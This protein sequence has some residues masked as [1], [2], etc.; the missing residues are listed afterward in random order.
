MSNKAASQGHGSS[1]AASSLEE[2]EDWMDWDRTTGPDPSGGTKDPKEASSETLSQLSSPQ[3]S[4]TSEMRLVTSKKRK[5]SRENDQAAMIVQTPSQDTTSAYNRSHSIIEKRYRTNLNRKIAD[6]GECIPNLR[7]DAKKSLNGTPVTSAQKHNK[8][9]V[10]ME[11]IEYIHHLERRNA[12]LQQSNAALQ[13]QANKALSE[14]AS[15]EEPKVEEASPKTGGPVFPLAENSNPPEMSEPVQGMIRVPEDF[16]RLWNNELQPYAPGR[17]SRPTSSEGSAEGNVSVKGKRYIGRVMLGSLAGLMVM[18]GLASTHKGKREDRGLSSLPLFRS[19]PF[20]PRFFVIR[21]SVMFLPYSTLHSPFTSAFLVFGLLGLMLFIYLF[22]SRPPARKTGLSLR[23]QLQQTSRLQAAPSLASPLEVR[24]RAW[25]TSIQTVWVPRHHVF[26]E[27]LALIL[28]TATYLTRLLLGW[29]SYSWLTG[30]SEEEEVA[31]V[32]AW[33]IAI[34]AQLSGGDPEISR[35]RLVLTLWA[36]GTLPNTPYRLMLKALHLRV[37]FWQ[38]SRFQWLSE[39]L[40]RVAGRLARYQW[41]KA[42]RMQISLEATAS[43][44]NIEP[45]SEHLNALL[46]RSSHEAMTDSTVQRAH[47]LVWNRPINEESHNNGGDVDKVVEDSAMRGPL[48]ALASWYSSVVLEDALRASLDCDGIIQDTVVLCNLDL[49]LQTAASGSFGKTRALAASAALHAGKRAEFTLDLIQNL[50]SS[51]PTE[52]LSQSSVTSA[53]ASAVASFC[54]AD[55]LD[56]LAVCL[57]CLVVLNTLI[58]P[59]NKAEN[60]VKAMDLLQT[61]VSE[62]EEISL[63]GFAT[64]HALLMLTSTSDIPEIQQVVGVDYIARRL[65]DVLDSLSA[66]RTH[67]TPFPQ[68]LFVSSLKR[69][70]ARGKAPLGERRA[71]GIS[72]DTGYESMD[73][74]NDL[75]KTVYLDGQDDASA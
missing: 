60:T 15:D 51:T 66:Q 39:L 74:E 31:R 53:L 27:L 52:K 32:R 19:L 59:A 23:S 25:L 11:A 58:D 9:T 54:G 49:A 13:D 26:P 68:C 43:E 35:S 73:D 24:Q 16:R 45:L 48:D 28:E 36:A 70:L 50:S 33:D 6:L 2:W 17:S 41:T 4:T 42:H 57:K 44:S 1:S 47:N 69:I 38:P 61:I 46:Q 3:T 12:Y 71:S 8:A 40:H 18:D 10:L 72:H 75:M 67:L 5:V 56:D 37:L 20:S 64:F 30:R 14:S 7:A 21:S 65:V 55:A 29:Q 62:A 22:N 63:L 34:D